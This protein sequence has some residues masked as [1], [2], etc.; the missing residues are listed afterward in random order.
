M[1]TK[2]IKIAWMPIAVGA[3]LLGWGLSQA[4]QEQKIREPEN[5]IA[6]LKAKLVELEHDYKQDLRQLRVEVDLIISRLERLEAQVREHE[7]LWNELI[8]T[9]RYARNVRK[10]LVSS[11]YV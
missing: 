7:E 11:P 9:L 10:K 6:Y 8:Q 1:D 5:E 3:F 2:G 4:F